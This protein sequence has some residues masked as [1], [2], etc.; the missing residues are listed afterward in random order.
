[1]QDKVGMTIGRLEGLLR[2]LTSRRP[3]VQAIVAVES[4]DRSFGW[5]GAE[6]M[7]AS[8]GRVVEDTPFFIAS[9]DKLYNA[10]ITMMLDEAGNLDVDELISTY[11]PQTITGKLHR[12]EGIDFSEKIT[13]RHL[14]THTSGLADWL[15]DYPRGGPSL[16]ESILEEGDRIL[17]IEELVAHVRDQLKPHFPPQDL[18]GRRPKVRYSDTNFMLVTAIIE[19]VTGQPLHEVHKRMLHEPLGLRQTYFPGL[20]RSIHPT[21]APMTLRAR[22]EPLNI[23]HLIESVRGIYSTVADMMAFLRALMSGEVFRSQE[24][25]TTMQSNWH[26]FGFPLDRSALRCPGWPIEYGTGLMRFRLPRLF[27]LTTRMPAVLGHTGSTGCWLFYCP[28]RDLF[29]AGSV[30]EV[31]AGAVPFRTVPKILSILRTFVS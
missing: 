27:T 7:T 31:T 10:T 29:L 6:G 25:L 24:T 2:D 22:A 4:G 21:T 3:I 11:L 17:T 20:S 13:V 18:F 26:R 15:E 30:D 16:I 1:M 5:I 12:Y 28:E 14:L 23:P 8:G 9:I 19:A